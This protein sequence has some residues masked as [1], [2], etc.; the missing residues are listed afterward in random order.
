MYRDS[1]HVSGKEK[2]KVKVVPLRGFNLGMKNLIHVLSHTE[3]TAM[4]KIPSA[5]KSA[6]T[7]R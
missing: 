3:E 7:V 6:Y 2:K 1:K 4:P 5:F